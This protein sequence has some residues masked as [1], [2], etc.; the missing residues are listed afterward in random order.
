MTLQTMILLILA[1]CGRTASK[2]AEGDSETTLDT[3]TG[4]CSGSSSQEDFTEEWELDADDLDWL[5]GLYGVEG[6]EA[7]TCEQ[8]CQQAPNRLSDE[9]TIAAC[10]LDLHTP[11]D[12][13]DTLSATMLCSGTALVYYPCGRRPQGHVAE[14]CAQ[15][16]GGFLARC[17]H[18]EAASVGAFLELAAQ[19][20][21]LGAPAALLARCRQAA[22]EERDHAAQMG[23]LAR[24]HGGQIP[25]AR[26]LPG[27]GDLE[28]IARHNAVEGCVLETWSALVVAWQGRHAP[29]PVLRA[30]C[31][32]IAE[33]EIR[34]AQLAW[35]LHRWLC[36]QLSADAR[37]RVEAAQAEALVALEALAQ[38]QQH[39]TP[40]ALGMPPV[41]AAR[42]LRAH[43]QQAA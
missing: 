2:D 5:V 29:D 20:A 8:V 36:A 31:A 4:P 40:A 26:Q 39:D 38:G 35:D 10:T 22:D 3:D 41:A 17:A 1:G 11:A 32:R 42:Q 9:L 28:S 6:A 37:A 27:A 12:T 19:L 15:T 18:L 30:A 14:D 34:H 7:L 25:P 13:A 43:L 24:L 21:A 23:A 16:L 33:D